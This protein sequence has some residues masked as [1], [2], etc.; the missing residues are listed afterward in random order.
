M[1]EYVVRLMNWN[2]LRLLNV[3]EKEL[4][5]SVVK[6]DGLEMRISEDYFGGE[7]V[8]REEVIKLV[9]ECEIV[10]LVGNEIVE[11]VVEEGLAN[12]DAVRIIGGVSFLMIF[13][14]SSR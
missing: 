9:K 6:G 5:G 3:C 11:A 13:K 8:E 1:A 12:G 7:V 4:L 10:N 14:F 2:G